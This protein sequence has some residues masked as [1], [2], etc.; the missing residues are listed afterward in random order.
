[1]LC[2][3]IAQD[4][5]EGFRLLQR[6]VVPTLRDDMK[7]SAPRRAGLR[8]ADFQ[9]RCAVLRTRYDDNGTWKCREKLVAT[10]PAVKGRYA[11]RD[12]ERR[13]SKRYALRILDHLAVGEA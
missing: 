13:L 1:M 12:F 7:A 3:Y 4:Q 11:D 5:I 10:W 8:S 9:A 6:N 2:N